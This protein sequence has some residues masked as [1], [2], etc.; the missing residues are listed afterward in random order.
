[1]ATHSLEIPSSSVFHSRIFPVPRN[2]A[3]ATPPHFESD[4][5]GVANQ[6]LKVALA[7]LVFASPRCHTDGV[8]CFDFV[9]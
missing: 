2:E 9:T 1:M 4:C 3:L 7:Q 8:L 5:V 6:Y